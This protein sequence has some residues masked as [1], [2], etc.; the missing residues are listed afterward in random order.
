MRETALQMPRSMKEGQ[1]VL[2]AP[3]QGFPCSPWCSHG[4][5][6]FPLCRLTVGKP[7]SC[8]F[9]SLHPPSSSLSPQEPCWLSVSVSHWSQ[10]VFGCTPLLPTVSAAT[11]LGFSGHTM[12]DLPSVDEPRASQGPLRCGMHIL[13]HHA[14]V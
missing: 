2:P 7:T 9:T 14:R 11:T 4:K 1:E 8:K 5:T 10:A 12:L 3:E 6:D 13:M